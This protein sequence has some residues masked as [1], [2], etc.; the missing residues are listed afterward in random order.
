MG[1]CVVLYGSLI[2]K[3][4]LIICVGSKSCIIGLMLFNIRQEV[5]GRVCNKIKF[6]NKVQNF[7]K[8]LRFVGG[9]LIN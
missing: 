8:V 6:I 2:V 3:V 7:F 1:G 5:C 9:I 4:E